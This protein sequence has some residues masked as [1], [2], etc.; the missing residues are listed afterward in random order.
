MTN[1]SKKRGIGRTLFIALIALTLISC[2]FLGSTFA[3]YTSGG[4]G[5][6]TGEIAL[7]DIDLAGAGAEGSFEVTF[8]GLTPSMAEWTS[9]SS[10]TPR[11]NSA[12]MKVA[13]ITNSGEVDA[14]VTL[15]LGDALTF[16][17]TAV[18][19][20]TPS[21]DGTG[22]ADSEGSLTGDGA[23]QEQ[24]SG[25]F[26]ITLAY[27]TTTDAAESAT[28]TITSGTPFDLA[29]NGHIYIYAT[30]TWTSADTEG[31][32]VADAIDTWIGENVASVSTTISYVAVQGEQNSAAI[33]G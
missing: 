4:S 33:T 16:T 15:T 12:T 28:E 10:T 32:L 8:E 20:G 25:R 7:W 24:V 13:Q 18:G 5:T 29:V 2:C 3:R 31:E 6:A 9:D 22:Y 30:I 14:D 17:A 19:G 21:Y 26:A 1:E 27:S 23:S 11:E